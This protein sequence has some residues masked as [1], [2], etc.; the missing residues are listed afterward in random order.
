MPVMDFVSA[1]PTLRFK[2]DQDDDVLYVAWGDAPSVYSFQLD[3][4]RVVR[5]DGDD[6]PT[7][8]TVLG[9][10]QRYRIDPSKN[11]L[12]QVSGLTA[13]LLSDFAKAKTA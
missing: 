6:R 4:Y 13:R 7:G 5:L 2:Y 1:P 10:R 3:A 9:A 8:I 11:L 12:E